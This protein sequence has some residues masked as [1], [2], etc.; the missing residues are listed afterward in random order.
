[1]RGSW[2]RRLWRED[3]RKELFGI[4]KLNKDISCLHGLEWTVSPFSGDEGYQRRTLLS[5][6]RSSL[7]ASIWNFPA[8]IFQPLE[9]HFFIA[10]VGHYIFVWPRLGSCFFYYFMLPTLSAAVGAERARASLAFPSVSLATARQGSLRRSCG[11][12]LGN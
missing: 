1:M 4:Y 8:C 7:Q 5:S 10:V 2:C 11:R 12:L 6:E 3:G 9:R